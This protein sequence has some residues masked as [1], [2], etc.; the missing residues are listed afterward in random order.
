VASG[1]D[2]AHFD[3]AAGACLHGFPVGP[4]RLG[5]YLSDDPPPTILFCKDFDLA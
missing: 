4:H 2:R 3:D 1:E 5:P